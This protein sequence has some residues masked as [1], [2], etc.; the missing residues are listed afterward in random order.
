MRARH[1]LRRLGQLYGIDASYTD[2]WG[3]RHR[4]SAATERA[5]LGAMGAAVGSERE[6]ADSLREAEARPWRRMLAPVKV[7]APPEPLELTFTLPARLGNLA[8]DWTLREENGELHEGALTPDQLPTVGAAAVDGE[9]YRRWRIPLPSSLSHGYHQ[10]SVALRGRPRTAGSVQLIITPTRCHELPS[11][12]RF[13]GFGAQLY[14]LPLARV[15]AF[16]AALGRWSDGLFPGEVPGDRRL[17][18]AVCAVSDIAWRDHPDVRAEE[19]FRRLLQF[20]FIGIDHVQRAFV[21]LAIHARYAGGA[22]ARWLEPAVALLSPSL[23]RRAMILGRTL[24]LGYRFSGGV[25]EIR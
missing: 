25:P 10:L 7:I 3:R 14:G 24:L 13:W 9:E 16:A 21:A 19:S 1:Q 5:L 2:I 20:P 18:L 15:P 17:R 22:N 11:G 6:I 12:S 8:L 4:V 23:R